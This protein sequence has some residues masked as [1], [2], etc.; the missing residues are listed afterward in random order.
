MVR[1][2]VGRFML[3]ILESKAAERIA[4]I[5]DALSLTR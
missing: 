3:K 1:R 5:A 2:T 4:K